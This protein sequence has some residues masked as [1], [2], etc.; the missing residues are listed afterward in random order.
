MV[1]QEA[2]IGTSQRVQPCRRPG[3]LHWARFPRERGWI[4]EVTQWRV[5][6]PIP[7]SEPEGCWYRLLMNKPRFGCRFLSKNKSNILRRTQYRTTCTARQSEA[8]SFILARF[9][10][11]T[12]RPRGPD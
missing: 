4:T 9:L 10:A 8:L 7:P 6:L 2:A 5:Q 1:L 3:N 11:R 12:F